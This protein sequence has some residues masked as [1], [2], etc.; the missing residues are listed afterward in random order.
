MNFFKRL[1]LVFTFGP[2]IDLVLEKL[3][4]ERE[5]AKREEEKFNLKL[6]SKHKQE[7]LQSQYSEKNC[8]YCRLLKEIEEMREV[9]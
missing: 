6:C 2:E 4:D 1:K 7:K 9:F 3:R 8:D 5:L